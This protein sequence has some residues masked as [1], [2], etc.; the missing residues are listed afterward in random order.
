MWTVPPY[1]SNIYIL[2]LVEVS[3]SCWPFFWV[4]LMKVGTC[5][6]QYVNFL[7][8]QNVC[9]P[10]TFIHIMY[11]MR[12]SNSTQ[13]SKTHIY[14]IQTFSV[15]YFV[16]IF[17]IIIKKKK[18]L[19]HNFINSTVPHQKNNHNYMFVSTYIFCMYVHPVLLNQM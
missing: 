5:L 16:Y 1:I 3:V 14:V 13:K 7:L 15:L 17:I 4:A 6:L 11:V 12:L 8:Y 19:W 2:L 10:G 18:N 9:T